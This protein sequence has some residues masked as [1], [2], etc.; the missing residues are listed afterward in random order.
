MAIFNILTKKEVPNELP[1]LATDI[2]GSKE[3]PKE[4][5]KE[6]I[7]KQEI[8]EKSAPFEKSEE[9]I[10]EVKES[11]EKKEKSQIIAPEGF[12]D[13]IS[14]NINLEL[15]DLK[16]LEKWYNEKF[17]PGDV[18]SGMR[19]YWE[20]QAQDPVMGILGRDFK[21]RISEKTANLQKLEK[22]WQEIYFSL[23]EKEEGIRKE[24]G[25]LK[26]ILKEFLDLCKK[27]G[28]TKDEKT[29]KKG[30]S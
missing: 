22:Q 20:S 6:Q 19:Q 1:P 13:K 18:V 15:E 9:L 23:M 7:V 10:G 8:L 21:E 28:L 5:L 17:L 24:E 12:F 16:K 2:L 26:S 11:E 27:K 3:E 29:N 14:D 30:K 25:E 4:E